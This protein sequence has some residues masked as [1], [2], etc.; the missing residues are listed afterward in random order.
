MFLASTAGLVGGWR[1]VF[2]SDTA[3]ASAVAERVLL[4]ILRRN[5]TS[6]YG[7]RHG[8][9]SITS[10]DQYRRQVPLIRYEDIVEEIDEMAHR[11]TP[12]VL[13]TEPV[14]YF[15]LTSGTSGAPKLIPTTKR[16]RSRRISA[17]VFV[18]QGTVL[19]QLGP[20]AVL[21]RGMNGMSIAATDKYTDAGIPV[22]SSLRIGLGERTW[23]LKR[24]FTSP[25]SAYAVHDVATAY[26]VHW[27]FALADRHLRY[28]ADEF[29]SKMAFALSVL[30]ERHEE[31]AADIARGSLSPEIE[32]EPEVRAEVDAAL[33]ADPARAQEIRAAFAGPEGH[34]GVIPRVWPNLRYL[35]CIT[36]GTFKVYEPSIRALCGDLPIFNTTYGLSECSVAVSIGPDDSRYVL[37]PRASFLEFVPEEQ[38]DDPDPD[39]K[40]LDELEEGKRYE[41]VAS[42]F[43]GLYRYRTSDIIEVV[44]SH[45]RAPIIEFSHRANVLMNFNAEMMTESAALTALQRAAGLVDGQVVDYSIRPGHETFPPHYCFYVELQE[46]VDPNVLAQLATQLE[47][48]LGEENPR[49]ED[50]VVMGRLLPCRVRLV[51]PGGF[52]EFELFLGDRGQAKGISA[53][54]TKIPRLMSDADLLAELDRHVLA[55]AEASAAAEAAS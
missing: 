52:R 48:A 24:L 18:P 12:N 4:Q 23:L 43:A 41:I 51:A 39:T 16:E 6:A 33:A 7:E 55:E 37:H 38:I 25:I 20:G 13:T 30:V 49:Y 2:E 50:R 32:V 29:A 3:R 1:L 45:R 53:V 36:T 40:L 17:L 5:R 47:R 54:Q 42:N 21:G 44:G 10:A 9:A 46:A 28:I 26:Y 35:A 19:R 15:M 11:A 14:D 34:R 31:L 22:S 8:F 27:L